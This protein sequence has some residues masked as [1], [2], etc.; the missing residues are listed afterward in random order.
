LLAFKGLNNV[1]DAAKA[2]GTTLQLSDIFKNAIFRDIVLSLLATLGLYIVASLIFVSCARTT[3]VSD[4][5]VLTSFVC[6]FEPWHMITSFVQY[7]LMAPS[8][9]AV[10]NVYAV[11]F[12]PLHTF[13]TCSITVQILNVLLPPIIVCKCA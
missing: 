13:L 6:Q 8:Y 7:L 5:G 11:S 12:L 10:L 1:A 3:T 2:A 9:I 4:D